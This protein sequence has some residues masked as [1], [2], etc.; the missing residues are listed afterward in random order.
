[1]RFPRTLALLPAL[2][3]LLLPKCPLCLAAYLTAAGCGAAFAQG[4]APIVLGGARLVVIAAA[5]ALA[6]RVV[7][8][9]RRRL[10]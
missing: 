9:V 10:A 2:G 3:A 6:L 7:M 4:V 1:M 5:A 8:L